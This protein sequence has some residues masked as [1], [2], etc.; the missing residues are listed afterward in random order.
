MQHVQNRN[1][2]VLTTEKYHRTKCLI[3]CLQRVQDTPLPPYPKNEALKKAYKI[4]RIAVRYFIFS[5]VGVCPLMDC[6]F[7]IQSSE[8]L[9]CNF[10]KSFVNKSSYILQLTLLFPFLLLYVPQSED[11]L[12]YCACTFWKTLQNSARSYQNK[13]KKNLSEAECCSEISSQVKLN[14]NSNKS[15]QD[16][17]S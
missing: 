6:F 12:T 16:T 10:D 3:S 14:L 7:G 2:C 15:R 11:T 9:F 13:K 5:V 17:S 4:K 1:R 8:S